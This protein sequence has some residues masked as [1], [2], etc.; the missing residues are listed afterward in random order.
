MSWHLENQRYDS[1]ITKSNGV[2]EKVLGAKV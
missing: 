1:G 2:W